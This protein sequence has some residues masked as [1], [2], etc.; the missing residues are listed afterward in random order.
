MTRRKLAA[1]AV[2]AWLGL[3]GGA[4]AQVPIMNEPV[5]PLRAFGTET[6]GIVLA[7]PKGHHALHQWGRYRGQTDVQR[8]L[9]ANLAAFPGRRSQPAARLL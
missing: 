9:R 3:S 7:D 5:G 4:L 8:R 6:A 1:L 2:A